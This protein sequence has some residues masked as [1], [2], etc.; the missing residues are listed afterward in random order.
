MFKI[1]RINDSR[2]LD[3]WP[4]L[5]RHAC[6]CVLYV[7][8]IYVLVCV[9][10][11]YLW[12]WVL[13]CNTSRRYSEDLSTDCCRNKLP[14]EPKPKEELCSEEV[15]LHHLWQQLKMEWLALI[16]GGTLKNHDIFRIREGRLLP[17]SPKPFKF[18]VFKI[19]PKHHHTTTFR[20]LLRH[21]KCL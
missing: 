17:A 19:L 18:F 13:C 1:K 12:C 2:I 3:E 9:C 14:H 5:A 16:T 6:Y 8:R 10:C 20:S 21:V 11:L 7:C 15:N 4:R